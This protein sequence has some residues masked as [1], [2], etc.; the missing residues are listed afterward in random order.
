MK[1]KAKR[2]MPGGLARR[3]S[4]NGGLRWEAG[5]RS[6]DGNL[7]ALIGYDLLEHIGLQ[8]ALIR[9]IQP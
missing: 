8:V 1:L 7:V 4:T 2:G 5:I 6:G 3:T 9:G